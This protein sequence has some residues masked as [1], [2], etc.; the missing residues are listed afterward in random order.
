MVM[1]PSRGDA[2]SGAEGRSYRDI[3]AEQQLDRE[4][5]EV[6][7]QVDKKLEE[8]AQRKREEK[9]AAAEQSGS[10]R[11]KRRWDVVEA[12]S[13]IAESETKKQKTSE[14]VEDNDASGNETPRR[15][16]WDQ[17]P[18]ADGSAGTRSRWDQT[19]QGPGLTP[20]GKQSRWDQT[21]VANAGGLL[22]TPMGHMVG[23]E[24]PLI[25]A[26]GFSTGSFSTDQRLEREFAERNRPL[27][28][29]DLD[30]MLPSEGYEIVRPP[31]SYIPI[32]TPA[33]K[34][35]ET[36]TPMHTGFI[37]PGTPGAVSTQGEGDLGVEIEV[38]PDM[39]SLKPEDKPY[40]QKLIDGKDESTLEPE[41]IKE[42]KIMKLLLKVK[43]G[44][45]AMRKQALRQITDKA[46][47][48][49]IL[50]FTEYLSIGAV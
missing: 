11:R 30:A 28:D 48:F 5:A 3:I 22:A 49:I 10:S 37:M 18:Q 39:P 27:T 4:E 50:S 26:G 19:P 7:R 9:A 42:R 6:K 32:R 36:P 16:R 46:R 14:W 38:G 2:F 25:S 33:R 15:S 24:T 43:N 20:S 44:T 13:G 35:M 1:T 40:F 34:L 41:E 47:Y 12:T 8:E 17:T 21:P 29:A 23:M 31:S 45:P